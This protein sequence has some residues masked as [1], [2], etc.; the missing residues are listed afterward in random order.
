M[1]VRAE[2]QIFQILNEEGNTVRG[3]PELSPDRL[4]AVYQG[5]KTIR[6]LDEKMIGLQRQGRIGFYGASTGEEAA[7]IGS[8]EALKPEDWIF[9]AL[10]QGGALLYRGFH[11]KDFIS[12]VFG[13]S[14]D[15]HKGHQM[16]CHYSSRSFHHTAWSSC[17]ATQLPHAVGAG[18]ASKYL[19]ETSVIFA[20]LG[21]GA[22]STADF[23]AALN[24]AGVFRVPVVFFC[25]NNQWA[26]SVPLE[27]QTAVKFL[28]LKAS[29]YGIP[30]ICV[31]GNDVL[32]CY[33]ASKEAADKARKGAG[34]TFIEAVTFRVGAHTTSD[35]PKLYRDESMVEAWKKRD[36]I[37]RMRKFLESEKLWNQKME[38]DLDKKIA[39]EIQDAIEKVESFP[40]PEVETLFEDTFL[41]KSWNLIEQEKD[42]NCILHPEQLTANRF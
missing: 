39:D 9:P 24:F 16:P 22:T 19:N 35:D 27:K 42:L 34:P 21:D 18:Y 6:L 12:Q 10:R 5:M 37:L 25:Q 26:I 29:A 14:G 33:H 41:K 8:A 20:Y 30:G 32:A 28:S 13:N 15:L 40:P 36:P 1:A 17:I 23:H 4:L 31:D 2:F 38:K 7:V 11:L 3:I